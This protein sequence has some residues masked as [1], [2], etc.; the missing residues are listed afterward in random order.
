MDR[1]DRVLLTIFLAVATPVFVFVVAV[2]VVAA[3]AHPLAVAGV[4]AW[5]VG[6]WFAVPFVTRWLDRHE[7]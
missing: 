5:F 1:G 4:G 3:F 7:L 2:I 6:A